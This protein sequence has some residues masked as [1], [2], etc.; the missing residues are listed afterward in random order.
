MSNSNVCSALL[1][2]DADG[3]GKSDALELEGREFVKRKVKL[4]LAK[5]NPEK[6]NDALAAIYKG[7]T[8]CFALGAVLYLYALLQ[9]SLLTKLLSFDCPTSSVD[10]CLGRSNCPIRQD[11]NFVDDN[12]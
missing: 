5:V 6:V 9:Y 10:E 12:H 7:I 3:D 11:D 8:S 4:V 2:I 1:K